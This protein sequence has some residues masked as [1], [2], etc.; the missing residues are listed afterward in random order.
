MI[1]ID[2][3]SILLIKNDPNSFTFSHN[4][5]HPQCDVNSQAMPLQKLEIPATDATKPTRATKFSSPALYTYTVILITMNIICWHFIH[6][7]F[8]L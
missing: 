3:K 1:Y 7:T 2:Y 4:H 5:P 8:H 6:H